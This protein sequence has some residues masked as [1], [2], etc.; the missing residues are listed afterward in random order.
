MSN[1]R[2][3]STP[4]SRP[5]ISRRPPRKGTYKTAFLL[6]IAKVGVSVPAGDEA[7]AHLLKRR[8]WRFWGTLTH[9]DFPQS[10]LYQTPSAWPPPYIPEINALRRRLALSLLAPHGLFH[11]LITVDSIWR[12]QFQRNL[13]SSSNSS[14]LSS[15]NRQTDHLYSPT[16]CAVC[17]NRAVQQ[18]HLAG[19][20]TQ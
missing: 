7:T 17:L 6:A 11:Y 18:R 15:G 14:A 13:I 4:G 16:S 9:I 20:L 1:A 5:G 8:R 19:P 2:V 12:D 10:P 3:E